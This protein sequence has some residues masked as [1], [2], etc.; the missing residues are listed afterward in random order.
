MPR[1]PTSLETP[2]VLRAPL[3]KQIKALHPGCQN[4]NQCPPQLQKMSEEGVDLVKKILSSFCK[5]N[6]CLPVLSGPLSSVFNSKV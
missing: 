4:L 1:E 2:Q 5:V 3:M 6:F